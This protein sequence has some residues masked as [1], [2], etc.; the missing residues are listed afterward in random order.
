[1]CEITKL[2]EEII[3]LK[4]ELN[5]SNNK[6]KELN[7]EIVKKKSMPKGGNAHKRGGILFSNSLRRIKREHFKIKTYQTGQK[8]GEQYEYWAD[9]VKYA[10]KDKEIKKYAKDNNVE[11][12]GRNIKRWL[13]A[14]DGKVKINYK[15]L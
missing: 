4:I 11:I 6:I 1:M 9:V 5:E 3:R 14:Y 10:K 7:E 12:T 8:K 13:D 2:K 15:K